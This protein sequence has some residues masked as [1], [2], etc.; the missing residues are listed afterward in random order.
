MCRSPARVLEVALVFPA[1]SPPEGRSLYAF[2]RLS[3]SVQPCRVQRTNDKR[4]TKERRT[5][6]G[7]ARALS[8]RVLVI[9]ISGVTS[10][11]ATRERT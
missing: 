7:S 4:N 9:S 3:S 5:E 8:V 1:L 11:Q 2:C 6:G 10:G